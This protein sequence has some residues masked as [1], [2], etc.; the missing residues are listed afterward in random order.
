MA[1]NYPGVD[2]VLVYCV[3]DGAVMKAW[4][5]DQKVSDDHASLIKFMGD[6][7]G[8]LTA[9]LGMQLTDPGPAGV[10]IIGRC[11][12]FVLLVE[13]GVVRHVAVA[14]QEGDPAG[15]NFPEVTC[16]PAMLEVLGA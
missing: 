4:A 16:A 15:D 9:A 13:D 11:K 12:R 7:A 5:A 3:N 2:E 6:P 8:D 14:E 1:V 10:G